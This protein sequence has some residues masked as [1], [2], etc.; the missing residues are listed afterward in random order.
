M[1]DA[2]TLQ[3]PSPGSG[4]SVQVVS[5]PRGEEVQVNIAPNLVQDVRGASFSRLDGRTPFTIEGPDTPPI[6]ITLRPG[7]STSGRIAL[8]L[9]RAPTGEAGRAGTT[10]SIVPS[11]QAS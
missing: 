10:I 4:R 5:T 8:D 11:P 3:A 2:Q 7:R 6:A 1:V 9:S